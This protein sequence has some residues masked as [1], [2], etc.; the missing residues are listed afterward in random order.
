MG[1]GESVG[2]TAQLASGGRSVM[3]GVGWSEGGTIRACGGRFRS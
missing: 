1:S 2:N 3:D